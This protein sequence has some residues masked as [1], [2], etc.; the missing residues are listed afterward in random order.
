LRDQGRT[1]LL[2]SHILSEAEALS[3]R[4]SIIRA[5][6]VVE[7]GPLDKLRHLTRTSV[8]A[9]VSSVPKGLDKLSGVHDV[10]VTNHRVTAQVETAGL[11]PLMKALMAAGLKALTSQPPTLEDLFLR[12]YGD[13][14]KGEQAGASS[15]GGEGAATEGS[16]PSRPGKA[17]SHRGR[18]TGA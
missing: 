6:K 13:K 17:A 7:T 4:V 16:N 11:E 8:T 9:D 15:G 18:S 1:V 14:V 2:S 5:G 12:H 10:L 3:D